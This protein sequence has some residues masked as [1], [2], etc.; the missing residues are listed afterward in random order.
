MVEA[1]HGENH[2]RK[3]ET[4]VRQSISIQEHEQVVF[5][6]EQTIGALKMELDLANRE[7]RRA[8]VMSGQIARLETLISSLS[9]LAGPQAGMAPSKEEPSGRSDS[10]TKQMGQAVPTSAYSALRHN[11]KDIDSARNSPTQPRVLF[12][13]GEKVRGLEA[14]SPAAK[15]AHAS[16]LRPGHSSLLRRPFLKS[17][18]LYRR[19][20]KSVPTSQS[21]APRTR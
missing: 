5:R 2:G 7:D 1:N 15:G 10:A 11:T 14:T 4:R 6:L 18:V 20:R 21:P 17:P 12:A 16:G 9:R 19:T 8:T 3:T 13:T